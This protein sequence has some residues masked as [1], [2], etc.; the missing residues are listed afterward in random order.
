MRVT[1]ATT[2]IEELELFLE[3]A[4]ELEKFRFY[5]KRN[6]WKVICDAPEESSF[7]DEE[8]FRA[9]LTCFRQFLLKR[10][11]VY[12]ESIWDCALDKFHDDELLPIALENRRRCRVC[13]ERL[14]RFTSGGKSFG[15]SEVF[16]I[17]INARIFHNAR[18]KREFLAGLH[19]TV[20]ATWK[21][22]ALLFVNS[23]VREIDYLKALVHVVLG[24]S[25]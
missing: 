15:P 21:A 14:F 2:R 12:L 25:E 4:D 22:S 7:P 5:P 8:D 20:A 24:H 3:R 19:P 17:Y 13:R 1:D 23:A 18:E 10:D 16:D 9:F 6:D 11:P